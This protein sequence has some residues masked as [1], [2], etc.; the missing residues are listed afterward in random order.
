[1]DQ[2]K[3]WYETSSMVL[4]ATLIARGSSLASVSNEGSKSIFIFNS[5]TQLNKTIELFWQKKLLIEPNAFWEAIRFLKS[6][7]YGEK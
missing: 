1:M 2:N 4:T 5:S 3:D 6:R 7:I